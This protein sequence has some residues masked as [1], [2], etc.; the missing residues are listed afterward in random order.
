MS[1]DRSTE[2]LIS[3]LPARLPEVRG[4]GLSDEWLDP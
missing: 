2:Y 3:L 1:T 4:P